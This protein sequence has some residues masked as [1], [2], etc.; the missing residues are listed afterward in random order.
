LGCYQQ[1]VIPPKLADPLDVDV[2]FLVVHAKERSLEVYQPIVGTAW[3]SVLGE[4]VIVQW[5][6]YA[7]VILE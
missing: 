7:L 6:F 4:L 1:A 2:H 3:S 5:A